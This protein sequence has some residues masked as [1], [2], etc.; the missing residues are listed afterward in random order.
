MKTVQALTIKAR[1]ATEKYQMRPKR[2]LVG[3]SG[4]ADSTALLHFLMSLWGKDNVA[5]LHVN[6]GIR[7][8][9]ADRD[10]AHCRRFCESAGVAF[11][12]KKVDVIGECGGT[13]VEETA[14]NLRYA[15]LCDTAKEIGADAVALAHTSSDNAETFLFNASRGCG[16]SGLGIPPV[17]DFYGLKLIR[18]LIYCTRDDVIE[19]LAANSLSYVTDETNADEKY[20]RNFIRKN[21]VPPLTKLSGGA[22]KNI[23]ALSDRARADEDFIDGFARDYMNSPGAYSLENLRA[24]HTAVLSRVIMKMAAEAG[25]LT[26]S[27]V[28]IESVEKLIAGGKNGDMLALPGGVSFAV[29][30]GE[31]RFLKSGEQPR[32]NAGEYVRDVTK[33]GIISDE[34]GFS[35]SF[36]KPDIDGDRCYEAILPKDVVSSLK[37][38]DRRAGDKYRYGKMTR[39]LKKLTTD[40]PYD[41]RGR[42]PVFICGEKIVWYP[43]FEVSDEFKNGGEKIKIY[44]TETI[45]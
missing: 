23:S 16:I 2:T 17:R 5:A 24:L 27:Y 41:A 28:N 45:F 34:Y 43:G 44:Y 19:Y 8:E 14:R 25:G 36:S 22:L 37:I 39:T 38:R 13:A 32:K 20:S 21:I 18:P 30:D 11:Y 10:E 29:C 26:P 4:G 40:V 3:F 35:V 9:A 12:S 33:N 15:A 6:H 7:G 1:L 31:L 42:R